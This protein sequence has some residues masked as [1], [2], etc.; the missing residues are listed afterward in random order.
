LSIAHGIMEGHGGSIGLT[1]AEGGGT[2]VTVCFPVKSGENVLDGAKT[3]E[4]PE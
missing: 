2:K 1:S 4:V 3:R